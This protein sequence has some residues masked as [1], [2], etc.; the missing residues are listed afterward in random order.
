MQVAT[1]D[2]LDQCGYT[3]LPA[4]VWTCSHCAR[5][6]WEWTGELWKPDGRPQEP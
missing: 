1:P 4:I 2:K 5:R 6:D 3:Y